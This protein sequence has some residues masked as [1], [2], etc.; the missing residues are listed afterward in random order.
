MKE[1]LEQELVKVGLTEK[2]AKVY[3]AALELGPSTAQSI[4][5]KATVNR[6]T[7]YVMIESL[8]K[9]GLMSSFEKGKKRFFVATEPT[10]L[11]RLLDAELVALSA[12]RLHIERT[13][14]SLISLSLS[15]ETPKVE[16]YEG[17]VGLLNVH[18]DL[19]NIAKRTGSIDNIAA[20]DN[21]RLVTSEEE[22]QPLWDE[23]VKNNIRVRTIYS[24]TGPP[25]EYP[26]SKSLNW[27]ARRLPIDKFNFTGELSIY[28]DRVAALAFRKHEIAVVIQSQ[29]IADTM[30]AL[31]ELAWTAADQII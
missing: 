8:I 25:Q 30:R 18:H 3:L 20:I 27:Q 11:S 4:A 19:I 12:K 13:L 15:A 31:F 16:L 23:I 9:R 10:N 24:K 6:P 29:D 26:Q 7:T 17:K 28:G 5:A 22:M 2:E 21:S 14:P 1:Q